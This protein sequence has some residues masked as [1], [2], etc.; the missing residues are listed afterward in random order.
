MVKTI[1]GMHF[2]AGGRRGVR[3]ITTLRGAS[4]RGAVLLLAVSGLAGCGASARQAA[5][6]DPVPTRAEQADAGRAAEVR[7]VQGMIP[8]HRQALEMTAL[9]PARADRQDLRMLALRLEMSQRDEIALL[10]RWLSQRGAGAAETGADAHQGH[11]VGHSEHGSHQGGASACCGHGMLTERE[12]GQL[13]AATG[14]DFERLFLHLMIRH[15]EG[16]LV[17]VEELFA[18][19]GG[20]DGELYQMA[21][22]ID[23]DQRA[24]IDRMRMLLE[25]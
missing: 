5:L 10:E 14:A 9:V 6:G 11:G 23:S 15:H 16:A 24:E 25:R 2:G 18:A 21:A 1:Q 22:H 17:M 4:A 7:F 20:V 12:M 3:V 8:H 19:G 13:R